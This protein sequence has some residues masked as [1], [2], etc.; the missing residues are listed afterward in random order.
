M[1]TTRY[2]LFGSLNKTKTLMD[3]H[4]N[5]EKKYERMQQIILNNE[6]LLTRDEKLE[7]IRLLNNTFEKDK[8]LY[9]E[10]T[11][12]IC[13]NCQKECF[14][15]T[16]CEHCIRNYLKDNFL[17]WTSGNEDIDNLIRKCQME[18]YAPNR[19]LEWIPYNNLQ[20]IEY[21][22]KGGYSEIYTA[23]WI[24]GEYFQW[25]DQEQQLKRFGNQKVILK[26]L[27]NDES[28]NRSWFDEV[29]VY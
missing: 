28:T 14:A 8:I 9:N 12:R 22:T 5:L 17:Y 23:D 7:A 18:S 20:N 4:D 1:A 3:I 26:R 11:K 27:E 6:E 19:V 29:S 2:E 24:N 10:G 21:L 15:I 16:Y 25:N 13:D